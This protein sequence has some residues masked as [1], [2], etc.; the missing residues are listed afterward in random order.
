MEMLQKE[1]RKAIINNDIKTVKNTLQIY[2]SATHLR[3]SQ[4]DF[5]L[6]S[7]GDAIGF[8]GLFQYSNMIILFL[9]YIDKVLLD[10]T[11]LELNIDNF[12]RLAI[13]SSHDNVVQELIQ[14][15]RFGYFCFPEIYNVYRPKLV[16]KFIEIHKQ[17]QRNISAVKWT[18]RRV[19]QLSDMT[20]PIVNFLKKQKLNFYQ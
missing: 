9:K 4:L 10:S 18:F 2:L 16:T 14:T 11:D 15:S 5:H 20:I 8:S 13:S 7:I 17:K 19:I 6:R 12:V 3:T 1:L